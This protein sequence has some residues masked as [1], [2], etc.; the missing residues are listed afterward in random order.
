MNEIYQR[1]PIV[2]GVAVTKEMKEY[3]GGIFKD[4]TNAT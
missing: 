3:I 2:C 1:G 4:E